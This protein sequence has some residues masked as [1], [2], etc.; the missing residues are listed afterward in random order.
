[1]GAVKP[2]MTV[3]QVQGLLD[4]HF[5]IL[6]NVERREVAGHYT[7]IFQVRHTNVRLLLGFVRDEGANQNQWVVPD[8]GNAIIVQRLEEQEQE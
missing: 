7:E 3:R 2:G 8:D 6:D 1:M 5:N 4:A